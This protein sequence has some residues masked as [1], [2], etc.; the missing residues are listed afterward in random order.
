MEHR[1][2]RPGQAPGA[3]WWRVGL[4]TAGLVLAGCT[5]PESDPLPEP[6]PTPIV[7]EEHARA[8]ERLTRQLSP[9]DFLSRVVEEDVERV[10]AILYPEGHP[11][12]GEF[13]PADEWEHKQKVAWDV[14]IT[15]RG[16]LPSG[17]GLC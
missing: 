13:I 6:S 15:T 4:L 7:C 8:Y 10:S 9:E 5:D 17:L 12:A 2:I 1:P 16:N 14:Y 11:H 3:G